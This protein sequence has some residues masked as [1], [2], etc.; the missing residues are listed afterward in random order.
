MI[1]IMQAGPLAGAGKVMEHRQKIREHNDLYT[2]TT[3][4]RPTSLITRIPVG[5]LPQVDSIPGYMGQCII[6]DGQN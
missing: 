2:G 5:A 6:E 1:R 4:Y 3:R